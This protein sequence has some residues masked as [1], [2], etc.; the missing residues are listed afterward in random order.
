MTNLLVERDTQRMISQYDGSFSG[1]ALVGAVIFKGGLVKLGT[2][3]TITR[4]GGAIATGNKTLGR[5]KKT[6]NPAVAGDIVEYE[7]GI[8]LYAHTGAIVAASRGLVCYADD[9]NVMSLTATNM[10]AGRVYDLGPLAN[11]AWIIIDGGISNT[12]VVGN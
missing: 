1:P 2:A 10:V 9:D 3:G 7:T 5:A 12:S 6:F 11:T 4:G 8:F